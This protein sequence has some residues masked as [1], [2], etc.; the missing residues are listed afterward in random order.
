MPVT[1]SVIKA[2]VGGYVGHSSTHPALMEKAQEMLDEAK[3]R[4]LLVDFHV[5]HVGDDLELIMTH[6]EGEGSEEVH[7]LAWNV[8]MAATEVAHNLKLYGAGQDLLSDSFAGTIRGMGPGV[9]EM[10]IEERRS[11]PVIIFMA[12]KTSSGAWN[13]PLYR[14]FADPFNS[15]GLVIAESMHQGF[16][17]EIVDVRGS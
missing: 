8:F 12:D 11:E 6:G 14:I 5:T 9:A 15:A 10:E 7:K 2:D 4:G 3:S 13:L 1:L 17:F 16:T